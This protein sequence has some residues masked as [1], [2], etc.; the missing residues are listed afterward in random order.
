MSTTAEPGLGART[1]ELEARL[2]Q[3]DGNRGDALLAFARVLLRRAPRDRVERRPLDVLAE[4]G[5]SL[6]AF[7]DARRDA[8]AVRVQDSPVG[9]SDL[10]ANLP[11]APFLVDTVR[12]TVASQ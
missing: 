9:G 1:A 10:E 4:Q 2:A 11:D 12:E 3:R 8:I 6:F 7:V 5:E